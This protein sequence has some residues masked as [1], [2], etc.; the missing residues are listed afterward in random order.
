MRASGR[1][2]ANFPR[3]RP[4]D[5]AW[6]GARPPSPGCA[7]PGGEGQR[8]G[9]DRGARETL[10]TFFF[11]FFFFFSWRFSKSLGPR[12]GEWILEQVQAVGTHGEALSLFFRFFDGS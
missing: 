4:P 11:L 6:P 1:R 10:N 9:G 12:S 7:R 8:A 3:R 2:G 5:P